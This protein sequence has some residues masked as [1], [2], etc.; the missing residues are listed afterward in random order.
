MFSPKKQTKE[1]ADN[2]TLIFCPL[3]EDNQVFM[4]LSTILWVIIPVNPMGIS[5]LSVP[6]AI[7]PMKL[8]IVFCGTKCWCISKSTDGSS[9]RSM[10]KETNFKSRIIVYFHKDFFYC[11]LH[12]GTDPV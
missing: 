12:N 4:S 9:D 8:E 2:N 6:F 11:L 10:S 7:C 5:P 1:L 3:A